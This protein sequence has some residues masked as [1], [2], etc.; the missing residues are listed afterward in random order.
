MRNVVNQPKI[1]R[2]GVAA[3]LLGIAALVFAWFNSGPAS[4]KQEYYG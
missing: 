2:D 3:G 4:A 1:G